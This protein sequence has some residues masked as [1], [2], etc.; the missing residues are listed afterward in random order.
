MKNVNYLLKMIL[1]LMKQWFWIITVYFDCARLVSQKTMDCSSAAP[2][3]VTSS[4][5]GV[6]PLPPA[7][8]SSMFAVHEIAQHR[9]VWSRNTKAVAQVD[10][11]STLNN[12]NGV[13]TSASTN[14]QPGEC[15]VSAR[16]SENCYSESRLYGTLRDRV[17]LSTISVVSYISYTIDRAR[18][19]KYACQLSVVSYLCPI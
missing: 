15:Q 5:A 7:R 4:G 13:S 2:P 19:P 17:F 6:P 18:G 16:I 9:G 14:E 11:K 3:P 1:F 12:V 10:S 8:N